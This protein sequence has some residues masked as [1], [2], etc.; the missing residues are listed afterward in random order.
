MIFPDFSEK[1][2]NF[3]AMTGSDIRI[4]GIVNLTADSFYPP[5]R[6]LGGDGRLDAGR[7]LDTVRQMAADGAAWLDLGACSTR[8]GSSPV[9][10]EAEWER[11]SPA[12]EMLQSQAPEL[13]PLVSVD[14]FRSGIVRRVHDAIGPFLV[15]DI[16]GAADPEM[17]PLVA[18]LGLPYVAMHMR[19]TPET[20]DSLTDYP[21]GVVT[22]VHRW[23]EGFA[24]RASALGIREWI[25]DPGFGFAKSFEQNHELLSELGAFRDF[26]RP[27]LVGISRK[28]MV[29]EGLAGAVVEE[30]AVS[31]SLSTP[32]KTPHKSEISGDPVIP[33]LREGPAGSE[34]SRSDDED[35]SGRG[36]S[37]A[38][39]PL[40]GVSL[41]RQPSVKKAPANADAILAET[42]RLHRIAIAGGASIL[43]VH[44]VAA[45]R[46]L[47][48]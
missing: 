23:F 1:M 37:E 32:G 39:T 43:R 42:S 25:L 3:A 14:T 16:S 7:F 17:L 38:A 44:D 6:M 27:I 21:E 18:S 24:E 22:A 30:G 15:N 36:R 13:L 47:L 34:L 45:A 12:L 48:P 11:L 19:G 20:M 40:N 9:S 46:A 29:R 33:T 5:S 26:G 2:P 28:R 31:G 41:K 8:P 10:E 4:M 35:D